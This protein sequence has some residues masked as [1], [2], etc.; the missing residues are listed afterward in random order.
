MKFDDLD[1]IMRVYE[2]TYDISVLPEVYI[3]ARFDGRGFTRLT[4][5]I[6]QFKAPF[7]EN[8]RDHIIVTIE[9]L[10]NCGFKVIYAYTQSDE[11]SLLLDL[12][13]D[14][15][16]RKLR[17]LNSILAAEASAK[18][19]LLL[20][21]IGC[22]DCRISQ[23]PN[24]ILVVDYFRWRQ[25]DA[26]RNSLS[27]HCYWCLRRDGNSANKA[28][29]IMEGV[30]QADKHELLFQHGI[31]FSDLPTWEKR[32]VGLYWEQYQKIGHNPL[33]GENTLTTRNRIKKDFNLPMKDEYSQFILNLVSASTSEN[34]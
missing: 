5:E 28:T 22:F 12:K 33:T 18:F 13:T 15:F 10:M 14:I 2:T 26:Y 34:K 1:K 23:L 29:S 11:I 19:S 4:K 30:S 32:G 6:H 16:N 3:V 9:H 31:N 27:S 24:I 25:Q 17:K 20:K 8:F 7:D 21:N